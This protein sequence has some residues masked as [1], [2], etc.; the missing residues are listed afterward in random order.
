MAYY[1]LITE[2]DDFIGKHIQEE[3]SKRGYDTDLVPSGKECLKKIKERT[4]DILILDLMMENI[5]GLEVLRKL[6]KKVNDIY[7]IINT[8]VISSFNNDN[9]NKLGVNAYI[10]KPV[11]FESLLLEV[12][13]GIEFINKKKKK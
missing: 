6:K 10:E 1:I 9:L 12:E 3:L 4:P 7:I 13:K 11:P 2:D 8:I 5:P